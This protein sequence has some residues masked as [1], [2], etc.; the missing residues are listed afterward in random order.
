M[1]IIAE[2]IPS[3]SILPEDIGAVLHDEL[4]AEARTGVAAVLALDG[5]GPQDVAAALDRAAGA[6]VDDVTF[7]GLVGA[8]VGDALT[9]CTTAL[10]EA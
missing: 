7:A 2:P 9:R 6:A 4:L 5:M 8:F 10:S 1:T 3:V